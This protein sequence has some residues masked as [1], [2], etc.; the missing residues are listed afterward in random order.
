MMP[1]RT[2]LR[3]L[4]L[5]AAVTGAAPPVLAEPVASTGPVASLPASSPAREPP[6]FPLRVDEIRVTGLARTDPSIVRNELGFREGDVITA[7]RFELGLARLWNM[8]IFAHVDGAIVREGERYVAAFELEDRWTLNPLFSFGSGGSASYFRVGVSDNNIAG[9]FLEAQAQYEN[10]T[11][12]HGGQVI[13]HEPRLFGRRLEVF[14]RAERLTRPRPG[15]SDQRALGMLEIEALALD[16]RLR[17]GARVSAFDDR[18]VAPLDPPLYYPAPTQTLLVEPSLRAGRLDTVRLRQRGA[19]LELRP[20]VGF[21]SSDVAR[22]YASVTG[23]ALAFVM[24][25]DRTNLAF[26]A[27]GAAV[28]DVPEHLQVYAGGLDLVRG[29][30][31]NYVR[32]RAMLL[33]NVEARFVVFDST[34][35]ALVPVAFADAVTA[36]ALTGRTGG[37]LSAGAGL[38]ILVPKFVGTGARIDVAVPLRADFERAASSSGLLSTGPPQPRADVGGFQLAFGVYQFF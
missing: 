30:P 26:R 21:T 12:F 24:I 18:F 14:L 7:E 22:R 27:R 5:V 19:T 4:L 17:Y 1:L 34:W 29:V 25:G 37:A 16:D 31:D 36:K 6:S 3:A 10:F 33:A 2:R 32:A 11:G 15:Y 9:R 28:S 38:R 13:V 23:E 8:Q 35:I 20:G